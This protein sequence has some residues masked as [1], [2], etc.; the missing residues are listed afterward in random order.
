MN[1]Y[2]LPL[3][4][5]LLIHLSSHCQSIDKLYNID[6]TH[7]TNIYNKHIHTKYDFISGKEYKPYQAYIEE[8]PYLNSKAGIGTIYSKGFEYNDEIIIYDMYKD[9]VAISLLIRKATLV[10]INKNQ[11][12][13]FSIG[14]ENSEKYMLK[15]L[16]DLP[17]GD[18]FYEVPHD[19]KLKLLIRHIAV[20]SEEEGITQYEH[21]TIPYLKLND[22]YYKI[23]TRKKLQALFKP[24]KRLI[25]NKVRT[26]GANF[27]S[28]NTNQLAE[29]IKFAETF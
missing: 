5:L 14:F 6:T 9:E 15:N 1:R 3:L 8:N 7:L 21:Q 23:N 24:Q 27:K 19:G 26:L 12:D 4:T 17:I 18:G 10:N 2:F 29:L 20:R 11:I 28:L 25:K 16:S 22:H 13:S